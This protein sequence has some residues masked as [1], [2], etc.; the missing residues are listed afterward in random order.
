MRNSSSYVNSPVP[1]NPNRVSNIGLKTKQTI[2][3]ANEGLI[4]LVDVCCYHYFWIELY[5][6]SKRVVTAGMQGIAINDR[7]QDTQCIYMS[8]ARKIL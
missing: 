1:K 2:V 5:Q 6:Y 3:V 4:F 7:F 8:S